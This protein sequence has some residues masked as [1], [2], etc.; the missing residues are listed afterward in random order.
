MCKKDSVYTYSVVHFKGLNWSLLIL[1]R[2]QY[3]KQ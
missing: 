1:K 2:T 3:A